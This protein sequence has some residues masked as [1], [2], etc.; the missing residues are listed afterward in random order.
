MPLID[1]KGRRVRRTIFTVYCTE[2]RIYMD[3]EYRLPPYPHREPARMSLDGLVEILEAR[4]HTLYRYE[5]GSPAS[6]N[7]PFL[8]CLKYKFTDE[9][10]ERPE[11]SGSLKNALKEKSW[12]TRVA[13]EPHQDYF[14]DFIMRIYCKEVRGIREN[15]PVIRIRF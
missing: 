9:P 1:L 3:P 2:R 12:E 6:T 15:L 11:Y 4:G 14:S 5:S 10:V 7:V 8:K 13:F